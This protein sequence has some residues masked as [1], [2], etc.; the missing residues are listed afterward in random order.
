MSCPECEKYIK[1]R[2]ALEAECEEVARLSALQSSAILGYTEAGHPYKGKPA[3]PV[4]EALRF[5]RAFMIVA[6][7]FGNL[8]HQDPATII[9]E[10]EMKAAQEMPIR[11]IKKEPEPS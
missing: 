2:D 8:I 9:K 4:E 3:P 7:A 6:E 11:Y 1:E 5:R 10:A